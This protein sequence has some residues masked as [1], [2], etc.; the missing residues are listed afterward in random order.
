MLDLQK[1][2]DRGP[3]LLWGGHLDGAEIE[4][5]LVMAWS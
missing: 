3:E 5:G 1:I 4:I 2:C